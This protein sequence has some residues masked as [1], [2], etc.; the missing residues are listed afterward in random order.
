MRIAFVSP[1]ASGLFADTLEYTGGAEVQQFLL[2]RALARRGHEP[3]FLVSDRPGLRAAPAG[4]P[5]PDGGPG[6]VRPLPMPF[7]LSARTPLEQAANARALWDALAQADADVLVQKGAG[8]LTLETALFARTVGRPFVFVT[9]SDGDWAPGVSPLGRLRRALF[10]QGAGWARAIVAQTDHQRDQAARRV[11][12]P[13]R[14]IRE[15]IPLPPAAP[16]PDTADGVGPPPGAPADAAAPDAGGKERA[17]LWVATLRW[18]KRPG[19]FLDLAARLPEV[20]FWVAGGAWIGDGDRDARTAEAFRARAAALP[21]VRWFGLLPNDRVL[22][23]Q[24]RAEVFV[25]TSLVEGFPQTFLEA[26]ACGTPVVTLGVDPD[27]VICRHG[28]GFH[29]ATEEDLADSVRRLLEDEPLRRQ[30]GRRGTAYV[31]AHHD[32]ERTAEAYEALFSELLSSPG[33]FSSGT[34]SE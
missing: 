20:P 11:G 25:N 34:M 27:E 24:R 7:H 6:F 12:V 14:V 23:L 9:A 26:W 17:V 32:L 5:A 18:F 33:H 19:S 1:T 10:R 22:A 8:V 13:A 4:G 2:A 21:N 15:G 30:I 28:L 31:R 3:V 29:T 16:S